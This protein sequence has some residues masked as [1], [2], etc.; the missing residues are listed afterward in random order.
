MIDPREVAD[1][2]LVAEQERKE[3]DRFTDAHPDFD[4]ESG[5]EA[6]RL[7]V[8]TKLER[9]HKI[10]GAKVGLTS[11]AKQKTMGVSEP[12]YGM[13]FD[14]ML[15]PYG[16]RVDLDALIHPRVE[17]EIAFLLAKDL[18]GPVGVPGVLAVTEAVFGAVDVIDSRYRDYKFRLADVAADNCSGGK[19][20]LGPLTRRHDEV[21]DLRL[22]GC[23]VRV[24]GDVVATAA[25]AAVIGHPAAAVAWLANTLAKRG[26]SLK[27]GSMIFAGG[28]TDAFPLQA[29]RSVS[30]EFD[31]LGTI[32]VFA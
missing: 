32:E 31:G 4:V 28:L 23:V 30:A 10:V 12:I 19:M 14:S 3:L 2:L 20:V 15:H 29:G 13:V 27:A 26:E 22:L 5:Y 25:G 11:R 16:E 17:P 1:Q 24:D 8:Q 7:L 6:Q 21:E 9:G 18:T